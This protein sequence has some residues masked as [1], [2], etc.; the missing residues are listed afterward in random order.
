MSAVTRKS[1]QKEVIEKGASQISPAHI[2]TSQG[3]M[4]DRALPDEVGC[5]VEERRGFAEL[6]DDCECVVLVVVQIIIIRT[7]C[8]AASIK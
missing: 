5:L 7:I 8:S 6:Q 3:G 1:A 2:L 4:M